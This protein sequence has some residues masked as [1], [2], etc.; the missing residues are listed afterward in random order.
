MIRKLIMTILLQGILLVG[1][2]VYAHELSDDSAIIMNTSAYTN[3]Y[4]STGKNIGDYGYGIS[5]SGKTTYWGAVAAGPNY[6]IGTKLYIE[7]FGDKIFTVEDR[8]GAVED[9]HIDIWFEHE[10]DALKFGRRNLKVWVLDIKLLK[11]E[12]DR[13]IKLNPLYK[14]KKYSI[15]K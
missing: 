3:H 11:N 15:D 13:I 2:S 9:H 4:A 7:G 8:G 6:P 10:S 14:N 12:L 5:T 1:T